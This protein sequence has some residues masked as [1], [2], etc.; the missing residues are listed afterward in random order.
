ML[1]YFLE[2]EQTCHQVCSN[3][4]HF[5]SDEK[6]TFGTSKYTLYEKQKLAKIVLECKKDYD[7]ECAKKRW[8]SKKKKFVQKAPKEGYVSKA[9]RQYYSNLKNMPSTDQRFKTALVYAKRCM[10]KYE[11]SG[12]LDEFEE[13]SKKRFRSEGAGRRVH[14]PDFRDLVFEWF[15]GK[16]VVG[17]NLSSSLYQRRFRLNVIFLVVSTNLSSSL[18]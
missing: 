9:V 5:I 11:E 18:Y 8:D 4:W 15:I 7:L 12:D 17:T 10:D 16:L 2:L 14:A 6:N 3:F 13:P 1:Q